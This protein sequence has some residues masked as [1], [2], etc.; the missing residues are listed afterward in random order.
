MATIADLNHRWIRTVAAGV[1][2]AVIVTAIF[3][4]TGGRV[5]QGA[6]LVPLIYSAAIATGAALVLPWVERWHDEYALPAFRTRAVDYLLKPVRRAR[7]L[8]TLDKLEAQ[9]AD[10]D[11]EG[12]R[13]L[14]ERLAGYRVTP[15][16]P[17]YADRISVH[18]A[19]QGLR[20]IDVVTISRLAARGKG[21]IA[22]TED[23]ECLVEHMLS[24]LESRLDPRKFVRIHRGI[25]VNLD[26]VESI[27]PPGGGGLVVRMRDRARTELEVPRERVR[28]LKERFI[29]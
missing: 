19:Q 2:G 24:E 3:V 26:W 10:P 11:R 25:L 1:A 7:L 16:E 14:L 28:D 29:L 9:R 22:M 8:Y 20:L 17:E 12:L 21:T 23:G 5:S 6:F 27:Q 15:R 4:L 13:A 18:F